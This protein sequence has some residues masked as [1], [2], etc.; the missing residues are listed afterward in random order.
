MIRRAYQLRDFVDEFI[1]ENSS[2]LRLQGIA[3]DKDE[4]QSLLLLG[5]LLQPFYEITLLISR[6]TNVRVHL[7]FRLYGA[8]FDHLERVEQEVRRSNYSA[9]EAILLAYSKAN[10][11]L[12]KYYS[13][14]EGKGGLIYNLAN[15]LDPTV[16]LN[17]YREW[18]EGDRNDGEDES[19]GYEDKYRREFKEYFS[20]YYGD[21]ARLPRPEA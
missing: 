20:K 13:R 8:L 10:S 14:T 19:P 16:K 6:T 12:A 9:K 7:A 4:W 11:K 2:D 3:L 17:L 1:E 15:I 18:D 21:Q 5:N